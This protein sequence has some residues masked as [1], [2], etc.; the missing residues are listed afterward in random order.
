MVTV[1]EEV[2]QV[3]AKRVHNHGPKFALLERRPYTRDPGHAIEL[4]VGITFLS[5]VCG[6]LTMRLKFDGHV[7]RSLYMRSYGDRHQSLQDDEQRVP[8][9]AYRDRHHQTPPVRS[10]VAAGT[11]LRY[12]DP[13]FDEKSG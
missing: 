6:K 11:C 13:K 7:L 10:S 12:G 1:G 8:C 3:G 5:E 9:S 2:F 4:F